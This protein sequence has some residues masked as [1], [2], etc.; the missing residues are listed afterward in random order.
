[1]GFV[2]AS[3]LYKGIVVDNKDPS[4]KFHRVRVRI[5]KLHGLINNNKFSKNSARDQFQPSMNRVEDSSLPW[6]EVAFPF[7]TDVVPE[8]GQVVLVG[9]FNA[10]VSQPVVLGWLGYNYTDLEEQ[11]NV[12]TNIEL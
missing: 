11:F 8:I 2:K 10:D 7:D 5:P 12:Q 3:G 9:F 1:M 6:C 4:G